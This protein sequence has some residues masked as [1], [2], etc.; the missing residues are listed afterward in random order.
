MSE[1]NKK[2][3]KRT[4]VQRLYKNF[5]KY[6]QV[7]IINLENVGSNQVQDV[8]HRLRKAKKGE[9]IVGKNTLIKKAISIRMA[10]PEK[11]DPDYDERKRLYSA[12]P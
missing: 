7:L 12:I 5:S 9:M 1:S 4:L 8:R 11:S 3:K 6:K 10:E 2:L